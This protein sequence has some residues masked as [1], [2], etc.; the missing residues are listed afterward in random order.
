V[1][2]TSGTGLPARPK[3]E[4]ATNRQLGFVNAAPLHTI[5][6]GNFCPPERMPWNYRETLELAGGGSGV[7]W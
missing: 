5:H 1:L 7:A 3:S 2:R 6:L 4:M